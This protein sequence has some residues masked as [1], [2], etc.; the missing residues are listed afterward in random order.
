MSV[1]AVPGVFAF[2]VADGPEWRLRL[3]GVASFY[4]AVKQSNNNKIQELERDHAADIFRCDRELEHMAQQL[5]DSKQKMEHERMQFQSK[6][7]ELELVSD[8]RY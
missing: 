6:L 2:R 1:V 4:F 7:D 8:Q 5:A 3:P